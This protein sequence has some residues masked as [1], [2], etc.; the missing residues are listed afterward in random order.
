MTHYNT[1]APAPKR[2]MSTGKIVLIIVLAVFGVCGGGVLLISAMFG[3]AASVIEHDSNDRIKDVTITSCE[4]TIIDTFEAAYTV[5]NTAKVPRTYVIEVEAIAADGTR[6]G[7]ATGW[8]N[9]VPSGGSAKGTA[10]GTIAEKGKFTCRLVA[11]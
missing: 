1:P 8:E 9:D 5:T 3:G 2:G 11:G 4:R 6:L 10:A 7:S